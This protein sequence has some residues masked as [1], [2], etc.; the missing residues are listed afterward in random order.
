VIFS[1]HFFGA[2]DDRPSVALRVFSTLAGMHGER[3]RQ[4]SIRQVGAHRTLV[5]AFL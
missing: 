2:L 1:A 3:R 4:R 5:A